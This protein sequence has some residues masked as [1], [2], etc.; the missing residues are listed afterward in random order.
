MSGRRIRSG[1][2]NTDEKNHMPGG[3]E[4]GSWI[5]FFSSLLLCVLWPVFS[6][7]GPPLEEESF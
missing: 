4:P 6:F 2:F 7:S 3:H 1:A 5:W